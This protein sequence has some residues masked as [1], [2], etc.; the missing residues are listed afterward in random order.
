MPI[1]PLPDI[2]DV[3][4][5]AALTL[6]STLALAAGHPLGAAGLAAQDP[7]PVRP[8]SPG[9]PKIV[10]APPKPAPPQTPLALRDVT[11]IDVTDGKLVPGQTVLVSGSHIQTIGPTATVTVPDSALVISAEGKFLIPGMWDMHVHIDERVGWYP[12]LI[13]NGITGVREMAQR[14]RHGTDSFRVWQREVMDGKRIGPRSYGPSADLT[15]ANGIEL[16]TADDARRVIDSLKAAGIVFLKYH[17]D[18]GDPDLFFAIAREARRAGLPLV[19]H[20]TEL[21]SDVEA[22]DS[23]MRSVEHAQESHQ[24]GQ[25]FPGWPEAP[26]TPFA[27]KRCGPVAQA[28]IRNGT[29]LTPTLVVFYYQDEGH[30]QDAQKF[31]QTM[32]SLGVR[33]ILAGSDASQ[34]GN[35]LGVQLDPGFSLLQ[36]IVLLVGGGLT[37]LEAVQS[38]TLNPAKLIGGTDSLGTVAEG[39]L[40]DLVLLDDNPVAD[41]RNILKVRAVVANGRYFD[42]PTLDAMDPEGVKRA[43]AFAEQQATVV[44][45]TTTYPKQRDAAPV[46]EPDKDTGQ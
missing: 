10:S 40:A 39:K 23:G 32:H 33:R 28:F 41:I 17:D 13:A 8:L 27:K 31:L 15:N 18:N 4:R 25:S 21:A 42:R 37:P 19:G 1:Q 16:K 38:A 14:F 20:L 6:A 26:G 5:A 44:A 11:V 46:E 24:C 12:L 7:A 43:K 30:T 45:P 2:A 35:I 36:E 29:W 34:N 9:K 22:S 3:V